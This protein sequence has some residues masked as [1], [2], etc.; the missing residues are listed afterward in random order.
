MNAGNQ[1]AHEAVT[2]MRTCERTRE[3]FLH[4]SGFKQAQGL[5]LPNVGLSNTI[6][7]TNYTSIVDMVRFVILTS[8]NKMTVGLATL[9]DYPNDG[10]RSLA[11]DGAQFREVKR[12]LSEAAALAATSPSLRKNIQ[13]LHDSIDRETNQFRITES[14]RMQIP[15]T[16][17]HWLAVVDPDGEIHP[18]CQCESSLGIASGAR[19]SSLRDVWHGKAYTEFREAARHLP[20]RKGEALEGCTCHSCDFTPANLTC[21]N[22]LHPWK[23][24]KNLR[25]SPRR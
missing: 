24:T 12:L 2:L 23:P 19:G 3:G 9:D 18:C 4:L 21:Y 6:F 11:L 7:N 20:D 25:V 15:R 14:V 22:K 17:G 5:S 8:A 16:V 1:A 13:A 10:H